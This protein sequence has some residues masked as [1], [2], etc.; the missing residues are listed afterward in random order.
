MTPLLASPSC[1]W[2][3]HDLLQSGVARYAGSKADSLGLLA[4]AGLARVAGRNCWAGSLGWDDV[5]R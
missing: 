5:R 4:F 3:E 1:G 2:V